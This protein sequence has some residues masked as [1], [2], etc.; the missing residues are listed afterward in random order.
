MKK[1]F[2]I[3]FPFDIMQNEKEQIFRDITY[4]REERIENLMS[5][6]TLEEKIGFLHHTAKDVPRLGIKAY[7]HGNEA[8]HGVVRPGKATV[9]PQAIAFGATWDP[10]LILKVSTAISDEARAKH[11]H[12]PEALG[13]SNG[14]LTFGLAVNM[15]RSEMGHAQNI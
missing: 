1:I 10:E 3:L 4:S 5:L 2:I 14:L 11:H 7:Y 15:A 6:L 13:I 8:L 12:E 9:F